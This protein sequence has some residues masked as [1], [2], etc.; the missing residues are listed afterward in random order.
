MIKV[1]EFVLFFLFH[2]TIAEN[3]VKII[4]SK[5]ISILAEF[6]QKSLWHYN[7]SISGINLICLFRL[8]CDVIHVRDQLVNHLLLCIGTILRQCLACSFAHISHLFKRCWLYHRLTKSL[9]HLSRFIFFKS[10]LHH[11]FSWL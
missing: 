4:Y 10:G 11:W 5:H 2:K 8:I 1:N 6:I 9:R 3:N 7:L